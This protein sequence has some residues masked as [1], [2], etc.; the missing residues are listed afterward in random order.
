MKAC[1]EQNDLHMGRKLHDDLCRRGLLEKNITV[2]NAI[3]NMYAK[4]GALGK[5]QEVFDTLPLQDVITWNTL[6]GGYAQ[7]GHGREALRCF[8]EMQRRGFTCT[9]V[10]IV[11]I[12]KACGSIDAPEVGEQV[13]ARIVQEGLLDVNIV[14]ANALMD[15]YIKCG[16]L[17]QAQEVFDERHDLNVVSWNIL[18]TGYIQHEHTEEA[19]TCF[20]QMQSEGFAPNRVTFVGV[21]K[22]CGCQRAVHKG[23]ELHVVI[24]REGLLEDNLVVGTA[25][26]DMYANCGMLM[27][28]K[29]VFDDLEMRDVVS[30]TALITGYAQH[31]HGH[32]ALACFKEMQE[33]GLSP[34]TITYAGTLRAC[35]SINDSAKGQDLHAQALKEGLLERDFVVAS[36]LV[37]MYA[38]A[39]LLKRAQAAFDEVQGRDVLIWNALIGGYAQH[40]HYEKT[41]D[42]FDR[43]LVEGFCPDAVTYACVLKACGSI[44]TACKGQEL[45]DE[46]ARDGFWIG[47]MVLGTAL[48]DMYANCGMLAEA[49]EVFRMLPVRDG[50]AWNALLVGY[51]QLGE[52][53]I[54]ANLFAEMTR[55]GREPSHVT[56]T[57]VL[58]ACCHRGLLSMGQSCFEF[59]ANKSNVQP[60]LEHFSCIIDL[61]GRAGHLDLAVTVMERMPLS[62][63]PTMWHAFLNACI[64]WGHLK[65]GDWAFQQALQ[66]DKMDSVAYVCM[67]NI[68]AVGA[69]SVEDR[70]YMNL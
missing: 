52:A 11:C 14:V 53:E 67:N 8:E 47:D 20:D 30:W 15:M 18:I 63:N 34:N 5:A 21:L 35:G 58:N 13:H 31:G 57:V 64:T 60:A 66:L 50:I 41:L 48:V 17:Q 2:G 12:L 26:V 6:I 46:I 69:M 22:A 61:F 7:H 39:G 36:A 29:E 68:C 37:D 56:F 42:C 10:T 49:Q 23:L 45:H 1:A 16:R 9:A 43:M 54:V 65:L 44:G 33:E 55:E 38:K 59:L 51:A 32:Q 25:L 28:A 40:E 24:V 27:E 4:C 19:L 62:V 70:T 3:I